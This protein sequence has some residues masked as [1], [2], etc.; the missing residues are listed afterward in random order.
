MLANSWAVVVIFVFFRFLEV[1][2]ECVL[3]LTD[4]QLYKLLNNKDS[5]VTVVILRA[6]V[7]EPAGNAL[8]S[9]DDIESVKED[10]SLALMELE[11]VQSENRQLTAELDQ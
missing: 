11:S 5:G 4:C 1:D 6:P 7:D 8:I 9:D 2:G 3:D 10:L